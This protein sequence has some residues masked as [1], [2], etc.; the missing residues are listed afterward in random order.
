MYLYIDGKLWK[1]ESGSSAALS[2]NNSTAPLTIGGDS[3]TGSEYYLN[4]SI[5]NFRFINGTAIYRTGGFVSPIAP[6]T[7]TSQGATE[8]EVKLLCCQSPT[9]AVEAAVKPADIPWLPTG[10]TY[11]TAG[12]SQNWAGSG[13]TT[14]NND[15]YIN[16]ALP[17]SGKYY[18]ET[19]INNL[20]ATPSIYRIMGISTGAAGVGANYTNNIFGFYY[21][22]NPPI[23]LTRN[24]SGTD[25]AASGVSHGGSV[26]GSTWVS[27]DKIMWAWDATNDKI[28]MG[29]NGTWF[30]SGDPVA[31]TGMIITGE[32]LSA[33][34]FYFK[35]GY[36]ADGGSLTLSNVT[37]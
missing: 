9:S 1:T 34:S 15:D 19:T 20:E 3:N 17:T 25:R 12:M 11:W 29:L 4:G 23:Y 18:W 5:S 8:S 16:V 36:T 13:G 28:Y 21:N 27:G 2:I 30:N 37:S 7:T 31:G 10:Y 33:S 35:L 14:S 26:G 24:A 32:D 6:L 22:G